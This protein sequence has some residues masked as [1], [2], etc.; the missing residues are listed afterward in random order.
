M[1]KNISKG[2]PVDFWS[3]PNCAIVWGKVRILMGKA[4]NAE[5][6]TPSAEPSRIDLLDA[7][8]Y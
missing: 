3:L 5:C 8:C 7:L 4:V 1:Y 2:G 6:N